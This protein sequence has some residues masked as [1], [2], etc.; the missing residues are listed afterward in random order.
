MQLFIQFDKGELDKWLLCGGLV[1]EKFEEWQVCILFGME[2]LW[3][4]PPC[5]LDDPKLDVR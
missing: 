4:S 3:S 1:G 2:R 5:S